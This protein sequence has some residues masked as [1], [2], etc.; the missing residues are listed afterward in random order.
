MPAIHQAQPLIRGVLVANVERRAHWI[1]ERRSGWEGT[2][3]QIHGQFTIKSATLSIGQSS[4]SYFSGQAQGSFSNGRNP[5]SGYVA[6]GWD[7]LIQ[8][9][10]AF[11]TMQPIEF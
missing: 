5:S 6:F 7:G 9:T 2:K 3:Q 1:G 8:A 10:L 4:R 11:D